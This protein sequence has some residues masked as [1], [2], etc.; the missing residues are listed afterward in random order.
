MHLEKLLQMFL[1]CNKCLARL[2]LDGDGDAADG[3]ETALLYRSQDGASFQE[4]MD[5]YERVVGAANGGRITG[6]AAAHADDADG[7]AT[8][9]KESLD[10]PQD[11]AEQARQDV[12]LVRGALPSQ[13]VSA[14][15]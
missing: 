15:R 3:D 11:N 12:G 2:E 14:V 10:W 4:K 8:K 1:D 13:H 9:T 5:T 7:R 6:G